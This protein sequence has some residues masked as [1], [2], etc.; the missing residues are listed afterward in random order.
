MVRNSVLDSLQRIVL[1]IVVFALLG[2]AL[3]ATQPEGAGVQE[4]L[5]PSSTGGALATYAR[6]EFAQTLN[7]RR[8]ALISGHAGND[9]GAVCTDANG[10]AT[11]VEA[12]INAA[13][14]QRVA[15]TLSNAG[16]SILVLQEY[17][18]RI[19]NLDADLLL[20]LHADSCVDAS[21]FKAAHYVYSQTLAQDE[22]LVAC[23]NRDYSAATGLTIHANTV[24]HNMTEYHAF[25]KVG[26]NTPA[27]ILEMGFLGGD[28]DLLQ[29]R[30][31]IV[32]QGVVN[33]IYCYLSGDN[34][35]LAP[36]PN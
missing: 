12:D 22:R 15:T 34:A 20:S 36:L 7:A 8:V 27:A 13:I 4:L 3:V 26:L 23:I 9:S 35:G 16:A 28:G 11:L 18:P 1:V 21:G 10:V 30:Q 5:A 25:R 29:H 17:D 24:T 32:A 2:F 6:A 31:D 19:D 14:A 33:A